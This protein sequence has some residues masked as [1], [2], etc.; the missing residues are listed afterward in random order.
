LNLILSKIQEAFAAQGSP[1]M[2]LTPVANRKNP[3]GAI[4]NIR[5]PGEDNP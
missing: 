3:N 4:E 2:L 1:Q 5:R